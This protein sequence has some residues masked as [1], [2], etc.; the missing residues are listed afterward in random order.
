M[1]TLYEFSVLIH[2]DNPLYKVDEKLVR[3][4]ISKDYLDD[5]HL[6]FVNVKENLGCFK[7]RIN[8]FDWTD[9]YFG[10]KDIKYFMYLDDDDVILS[11]DFSLDALE[12]SQRYCAV[13]RLLEVLTLIQLPFPNFD[14]EYITDN[15]WKLGNV[16]VVL[17]W[18]EYKKFLDYLRDFLPQLYEF[19]GSERIMAPDDLYFMELWHVYLKNFV[20]DNLN[21]LVKKSWSYSLALTYIEERIGRYE[22]AEG[23]TDLRYSDKPSKITLWE[24]LDGV[25]ILFDNYC[26]NN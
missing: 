15:D 20:D 23:V 10:G 2:N 25:R 13:S 18:H 6:K 11:P 21:N 8:A 16:G 5:E 19:V 3:Q 22:I 12:I 4:F 26:K 7:A 17:D 14:N 24:Q 1:N 9:F